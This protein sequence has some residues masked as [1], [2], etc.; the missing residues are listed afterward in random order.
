M[1]YTSKCDID[2]MAKMLKFFQSTLKYYRTLGIYPLHRNQKIS[3]N[4][5]SL[6]ILF[7]MIGISLS[8]ATFFLLKV[9][10]IVEFSD[11]FKAFYVFSSEIC[12]MICFLV[13][14]CG[15]TK[16]LQLIEKYESYMQKSEFMKFI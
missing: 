10:N 7:S 13:N 3:F 9:E 6:S 8:T 16:I 15:M 1:I 14:I 2:I 4:S 5:I 11:T 12:F